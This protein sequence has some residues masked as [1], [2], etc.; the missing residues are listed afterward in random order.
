MLN[1]EML[2]TGDEVLHGQ[3]ID[4]NAAW[5]ADFFFNQGLPLTRRNTVGDDLDAL[6]AIL[7]ERS[8]QADVLI[9]NGG[10]GPTS[11]DLS[12]LAAA[13]AKGEGLI[14]H[15]EWLETMTRFFA[16]RGRPMA[17]SNRKQAEIP[18][19][20]E[21]INNPVG[22]ACGFAIQL[23]RCLM[24][25]T[26]GVPSEFKVMVEQEILPRLRQRF[27][28]PDPPVCLRMTTFG[29][30]ESELAQSL[31]PLTLP[32]GVVMGYRSSMPIIELKLTGPAN[33]R[34]AMLALWPEVRKVAGD[35]LIFEGTE[36][37][38][39]QIARCLQE[40]QLSLTLSEQFTSGLLAL[41][42]SRAGAPLLASEVVPAQEETLAQAARWAA[43]RRINHFAGLALAVSGQE[44]DHLNVA[45]ATPDGTFALRVKF[46]AT[47][48]SLVVRQEVCAMMALNMLRRWL[49]G[50]PL[51][52]EHGWINVVDSLSL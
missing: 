32:P 30:S 12:A 39:A 48:H 4:T 13:T 50:Q 5:L 47:R 45:L 42:L 33:Q 20:A 28:L 10:L 2:S 46:S 35:S 37:L 15:P 26:P 41:Q 7:R 34:D 49:N 8:E 29:R 14:L 31:N 16:E 43:E 18:A 21:M 36:G 51:A 24:F 6:V 27:T 22:T 9:V 23:N 40:R 3:I 17:E 19:S 1:V 44:N 25:F 52:S 38:P 11:D